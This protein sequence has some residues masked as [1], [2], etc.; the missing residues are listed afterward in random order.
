MVKG[1]KRRW[2]REQ[3]IQK[4]GRKYKAKKCGW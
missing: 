2:G 1:K 3:E 4:E